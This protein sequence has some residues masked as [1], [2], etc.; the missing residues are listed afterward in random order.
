MPLLPKGSLG[1]RSP[2]RHLSTPPSR[3]NPSPHPPAAYKYTGSRTEEAPPSLGGS[4]ARHRSEQ[5]P[6]SAKG[7][8]H[9][10]RLPFF[11]RPPSACRKRNS[12]TAP[13]VTRPR[14]AVTT[15]SPPSRR[16]SP[17]PCCSGRARRS[18]TLRGRGGPP[19]GRH[20]ARRGKTTGRGKPH[21]GSYCGERPRQGRE[22][23]AID[24][25][26]NASSPAG[27]THHLAV[28]EVHHVPRLVRRGELLRSGARGRGEFELKRQPRSV[29]TASP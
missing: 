6:P 19:E 12:R 11:P 1:L 4:Q 13:T 21:S 10:S 9:R 14:G 17:R 23:Q 7:A 28:A 8:P 3:P 26:L 22:A 18:G 29:G 16:A 24:W 5:Q 2:R 15:C 27:R 20:F 25:L